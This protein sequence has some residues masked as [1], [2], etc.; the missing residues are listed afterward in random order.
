MSKDD[1]MKK[2]A[3]LE[4]I[5]F[6]RARAINRRVF[7]TF[8]LSCYGLSDPKD[9]PEECKK[10]S[11]FYCT[12]CVK[13]RYLTKKATDWDCYAPNE[14]ETENYKAYEKLCNAI[15]REHTEVSPPSSEGDWVVRTE[16]PL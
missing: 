1:I 2:F 9:F 16:E 12:F 7:R 10:C 13:C 3:K 11:N 15:V 14:Q 8:I 5:R 6:A 4:R